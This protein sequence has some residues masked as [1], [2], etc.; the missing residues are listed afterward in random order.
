VIEINIGRRVYDL[1]KAADMS[2]YD[3]V[4]KLATY[5]INVRQSHISGVE[6]G[7]SKP[8]VEMLVGLVY[9]LNT[10]ADYLL[11]LTDDP[12]SIDLMA[13]TVAKV[14]NDDAQRAV[15]REVVARVSALSPENQI[16]ANDL[17]ARLFSNVIIERTTS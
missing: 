1:R 4:N 9:S 14:V 6:N 2:Q 10:N 5:G 12:R 8:S 15:L 17:L 13:K 7:E 3:L 16:Y 11:G